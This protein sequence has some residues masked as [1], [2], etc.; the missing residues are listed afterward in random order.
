MVSKWKQAGCPERRLCS[1]KDRKYEAIAKWEPKR[2]E[3][4][5]HCVRRFRERFEE[6][7]L[8]LCID[9]SRRRAAKTV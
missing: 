9:M 4:L 5:E 7:A 8:A 6:L 3:V 2:R 1:R